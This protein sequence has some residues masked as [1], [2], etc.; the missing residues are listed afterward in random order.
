[1]YLPRGNAFAQGCLLAAGVNVVSSESPK[2]LRGRNRM[3]HIE[4][5]LR[6]FVIGSLVAVLLCGLAVPALAA[7]GKKYFKEGIRFAES[8]QWD[9]A[10]E[11][12]AL[13]VAED[14]SNVEYQLY[15]QRAL[16]N[17]ALLLIERADRL[18]S[19]K[20]YIAAY[21][22]YR[23][24]RALDP[25]N[26]AAV[27]KMRQM[28]EAQ[29]AF[30]SQPEARQE[31][32]LNGVQP[33]EGSSD[34]SSVVDDG[35]DGYPPERRSLPKIDVIV[36][37]GNL[38][39]IVEQ[40]A[41]S[42]HLNVVFDQQAES[43]I[44]T[45]SITIELRN[46]T[47][48]E[49]LDIILHTHNL[50]Y[51]QVGI[52]TIVIT[53]DN[54]QSRNRYEPMSV[55]AFFIKNADI[56]ELRAAIGASIGARQMIA[57][58]QVNA[59]VVRDSKPNLELVGSLI[60]I[61]DKSKA[62]VL[63]D[64]N[65]YEVSKNDLLR[66]GN[67]LAVGTDGKEV[68]LATLGGIGQRDF[69]AGH[70]A[71]ALTGPL[72]LAVGIPASTLSIFQERGKARLLAST[73]VHVLDKEQHQ[74]RIGQR[75]PVKTGSSTV[76]NLGT[77]SIPTT[78]PSTF[79]NIQYENVGL[80]IDMQPQVFEDEVQVKMKIESSS[81]DR[82]TGDLTPSFNQRTMSS[83]ARIKDGQ[84]TMIAGVSRAE[85]TR[86][87]RGIP[88][89]GLIPILGRFFTTPSTNNQQSDVVITVTPHILRRAD[90]T[91]VDHLSR[92]AGRGL[93]PSRQHSIQEII[94]LADRAERAQ[95]GVALGS[96][97][98]EGQPLERRPRGY[99]PSLGSTE[100]SGS[101]KD[102]GIVRTSADQISARPETSQ[103]RLVPKEVARPGAPEAKFDDV[104]DQKQPGAQPRQG[105]VV[106]RVR[107]AT[108]VAYPGQAV[109][110]GVD[111]SGEA[112][113]S[114]AVIVLEYDPSLL[115]VKRVASGGLLKGD[116]QFTADDGIL[117]VR[118]EHPDSTGV[119]ARGHVLLIVMSARVAGESPLSLG[120]GTSVR[121]PHGELVPLKLLGGAV[122]IR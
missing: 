122:E 61:L 32:S 73:Q 111:L 66:L 116:P 30:S 9:K 70:A 103:G 121:T 15:L 99:P 5:Y 46:V 81:V 23:Q 55:R 37:N 2:M 64:I 102:T 10:A 79:D 63:I 60:S 68:S 107:T 49:A 115:E 106:V 41:H 6:R 51:V 7:D 88:I 39:G 67:Q 76:L 90:I 104:G 45:K 16:V 77:T 74:I 89:I 34:S 24:A 35:I 52:R 113:V 82:S 21:N 26:E 100:G 22:A 29:G 87:V 53:L 108:T 13:A 91:D 25:T 42:I 105:P 101:M 20:D 75:V 69:V 119:V 65:L 12:L 86:Q 80:N 28:L 8:K 54:A 84:T 95:S 83:I 92:S 56:D 3:S 1:V 94:D 58:K 93:D 98:P 47:A 57:S 38:I 14:P 31:R 72:G 118:I 97:L 120:D 50:A 36:H 33:V 109:Y 114:S 117:R 11:R 17:A 27:I 112:Q 44:R 78:T 62:E 43:M 18:A 110:V 40:I 4:F 85:D 71:R 96:T 59:L 48:G 19:Q